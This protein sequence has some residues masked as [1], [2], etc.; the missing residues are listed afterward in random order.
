MKLLH[1]NVYYGITTEA[2]INNFIRNASLIIK[3]IFVK[4]TFESSHTVAAEFA[5]ALVT[6]LFISRQKYCYNVPKRMQ[7]RMFIE[8]RDNRIFSFQVYL[9]VWC[10]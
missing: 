7:Q 1:S 8:Q 9:F 4:V 10:I 6:R 5:E 3:R 2:F